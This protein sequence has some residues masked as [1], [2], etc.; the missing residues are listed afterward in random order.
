M[1]GPFIL[2]ILGSFKSPVEINA[3]AT[4]LP[5]VWHFDNYLPGPKLFPLFPRG[6]SQL[7][8]LGDG[9]GSQRPLL[10][11]GGYAF[12][13]LEFPGRNILFSPCSRR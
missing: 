10:R 2:S 9:H 12:A 5:Q 6:S 11:H 3:S 4:F 8:P 7:G 1:L 13:R